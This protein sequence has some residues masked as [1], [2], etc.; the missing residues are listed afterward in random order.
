MAAAESGSVGD[1]TD[2]TAGMT[3]EPIPFARPDVGEAEAAAVS[4]A[5]MSGWVTTGRITAEFE[6]AFA[7]RVGAA[8]AVSVNSATAGLHLALEATGIGPGDE[9]IVPTW[10]FTATAEVVRYLGATPCSSTST[11]TPSNLTSPWLDVA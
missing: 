5:V 9:V 3:A 4:E 8:H 1:S 2:P 10:T 6:R 11:R 7:E